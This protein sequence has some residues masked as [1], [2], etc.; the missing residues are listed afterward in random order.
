METRAMS[1]E[2]K[3]VTG[4]MNQGASQSDKEQAAIAKI[5]FTMDKR[6]DLLFAL[7]FVL[8]GVFVLITSRDIRAGSIADPITTKGM[9]TL[10]SI[11]LIVI[12]IALAAQQLLHW[13]EVPGHLVPEEGQEDEKGYP[14]SW[15]RAFSTIFMSLVW[16]V[17]L[18]SLGFLI[19][20]PLCLVVGAIFMGE[21]EWGK[22]IAFS[23]I[24]GFSIWVI[25]CP[26]LG[27]KF[28]M[29]PLNPLAQSL[30]LAW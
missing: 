20:T 30:G 9:P 29:G 27:I 12:G 25:F 11:S 15:V 2:G 19:V 23:I 18:H 22:I 8:L 24:F 3:A 14:A 5:S 13:S 21:R 4:D 6:C 16:L 26:L 7:F 1:E 17:L 28:P 10:A